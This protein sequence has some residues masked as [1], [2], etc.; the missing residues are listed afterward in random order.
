MSEIGKLTGLRNG[1]QQVNRNS[2]EDVL[3]RN[4]G[5]PS[6]ET[7]LQKQLEQ[8]NNG[9]QFSKHAQERVA[10]REIPITEDLL[11][12]LTDAVAKARAKGAKDVV[13]LD[14]Q[15][16][17]IVNI[18]NNIVVTAMDGKEMKESVFTNIDSAVII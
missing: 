4:S 11:T 16:A 1:V 17:F 18:P 5:G 12:G 10:Q 8:N 9:L 14:A 2:V 15:N 3:R 7:L 13:I 6:F